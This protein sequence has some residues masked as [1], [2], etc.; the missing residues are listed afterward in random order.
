MTD[1]R[2]FL[3]AICDKPG[4]DGPRLVFADWLSEN[5]DEDRAEF[6]ST[7]I[8][9]AGITEQLSEY[10]E[11]KGP[12]VVIPRTTEQCREWK[13]LALIEKI[14]STRLLDLFRRYGREWFAVPLGG[15]IGEKCKWCKNRG[16]WKSDVYWRQENCPHCHGSDRIATDLTVKVPCGGYCRLCDKHT[17]GIGYVSASQCNNCGGTGD[18]HATLT[19]ERGFVAKLE[20]PT[21]A[22]FMG[23]ECNFCDGNGWYYGAYG[24]ADE[25]TH[26]ECTKCINGRINGLAAKIFAVEPC[27]TVV[28]RGSEP[29]RSVQHTNPQLWRWFAFADENDDAVESVVG[30]EIYKLLAGNATP[31]GSLQPYWD[32]ADAARSAL[33]LALVQYGR[34]AAGV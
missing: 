34:K 18:A 4:E 17:P 28:V 21:L 12:T 1:R 31:A 24:T 7:S 5:G 9:L 3:D 11:G 10:R 6:I 13:R 32:T 15:E 19:V 26:I 20:C 30:E 29:Y 22:S 33:S 23:Q 14:L 2:A 8:E 27:V 25:G 16:A